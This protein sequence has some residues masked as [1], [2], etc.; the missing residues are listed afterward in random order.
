MADEYNKE[1]WNNSLKNFHFFNFA[2]VTNIFMTIIENLTIVIL[3]LNFPV[4]SVILMFF[5]TIVQKL[6]IVK[7]FSSFAVVTI[8]LMFFIKIMKNLTNVKFFQVLQ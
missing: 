5:M 7:Y 4:E 6:T 3:F 1:S 2:V 8:T